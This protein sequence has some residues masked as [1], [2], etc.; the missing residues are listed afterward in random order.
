MNPEVPVIYNQYIRNVI[1]LRKQSFDFLNF[2]N[3]DHNTKYI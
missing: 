3:N 2:T 1:F